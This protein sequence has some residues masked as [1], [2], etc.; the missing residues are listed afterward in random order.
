MT[1]ESLLVKE[2][3]KQQS[4]AEFCDIVL[5]TQGVSVPVHSCVLSA[6]SPWLC[7]A[8]SGMPSLTG[9]KRLI[10]VQAIESCTLLSL[11]TLM[12]SGQLN[13]DKQEVLSAACKL[14]INIPQ[15][16]T[17]EN[18][19]ERAASEPKSVERECQTEVLLTASLTVPYECPHT[20]ETVKTVNV[21]GLSSWRSDQGLGSYVGASDITLTTLQNVQGIPEKLPSFQLMNVVPETSVYPTDKALPV[22]RTRGRPRKRSLALPSAAHSEISASVQKATNP[23]ASFLMHT[24]PLPASNPTDLAQ[25]M[26]WLIDD[27]IAQLPFMPPITSG[28]QNSQDGTM[29]TA[30]LDS[31]PQTQT[32]VKLTDLDVAQPQPEGELTDILDSF[33]RTFDQHIG[34]CDGIP[35]GSHSSVT[36]ADQQIATSN[37]L[38]RND[39]CYPS[40]TSLKN[41]TTPQAPTSTLPRPQVSVC[42]PRKPP[43]KKLKGYPNVKSE[44]CRMTRSQSRKRELENPQDMHWR[45]EL[46]AKRRRR[47]K[48]EIKKG[49]ISPQNEKKTQLHSETSRKIDSNCNVASALRKVMTLP[50]AR[51]VKCC[52]QS[53]KNKPT[54]LDGSQSS[55]LCGHEESWLVKKQTCHTKRDSLSKM[56]QSTASASSQSDQSVTNTFTESHPETALSAFELMKNLLENQRKREEEQNKHDHRR[57]SAKRWREKGKFKLK[58][59]AKRTRPCDQTTSPQNALVKGEEER[60]IKNSYNKS[61]DADADPCPISLSPSTL[62]ESSDSSRAMVHSTESVTLTNITAMPCVSCTTDPAI[63]L[64]A[65]HIQSP[66]DISEE[67]VDVVEISSSLSETTAVF[68]IIADI[69]PSTEEEDEEEAEIDV[70]DS[71]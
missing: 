50:S 68:P 1:F 27:V 70:L 49:E 39:S 56:D 33:L 20:E 13:K 64:E 11:V 62:S 10:E 48:Q 42:R 29:S 7:G 57:W 31:H 22:R 47:K 53:T 43:F 8:L 4:K 5:R 18:E 3:Q 16:V 71:D 54:T 69:V 23:S 12:Y 67:D 32:T 38:T 40:R 41:T 24:A 37:T 63:P 52:A 59:G 61:V 19:A 44:T 15:Q 26:D 65:G 60:L 58:R 45:D 34:V 36:D 14:G 2:L 51:R 6:F 46:P 66:A 17:I 28:I 9:Q 21:T 30:T 25:P 35:D 55:D